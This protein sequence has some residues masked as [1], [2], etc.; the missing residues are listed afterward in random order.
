MSVADLDERA[1]RV[2][3]HEQRTNHADVAVKPGGLARFFT[4]WAT[5][6]QAAGHP[7][8]DRLMDMFAAYATLDPMQR[9]AR[10]RAALA[11]LA[12]S[13]G[14]AAAPAR[15]QA[16]S[17]PTK[18]PATSST[19]ARA[20]SPRGPTQPAPASDAAN[21]KHARSTDSQ[22]TAPARSPAAK[23]T[24]SSERPGPSPTG[25]QKVPANTPKP[26]VTHDSRA[27]GLQRPAHEPV[28]EYLLDA[29]VTSVAGVGPAI[30]AKFERLG[31]RTVR[32]LLYYLPRE[33][34][35]YSK[36]QKI[37]T[38]PLD[39]VVTTLG[40]IWE[41]QNVRTPNGRM[42]RTIARI[43][44]ETGEIRAVW[45][46]Q[47]Y[48]LKQ[49]PR[50]AQ[51][52]VTGVK[53]RFGNSIQFTVRSHELPEQGDL[54]NTG[55]LVPVYPLTEGLS[56][57]TLRRATKWAVDRCADLVSDYLPLAVRQSAHLMPLPRALAEFHYPESGEALHQARHRLGF[58]E[59]FIVQLGMLARRANWYVG[60]SAPRIVVDRTR[61][62][63]PPPNP[64]PILANGEGENDAGVALLNGDLVSL[65]ADLAGERKGATGSTSR[66][67]DIPL[68]IRQNGEPNGSVP[69]SGVGLP[70]P[71]GLWGETLVTAQCFEE[72][73]PFSF[74]EAQRRVICEILDDME[75]DRPMCRL[76]QGDVGS[77]KTAVAAAAM[78]AAALS[79][80]QAAIMAPTEILAE[81]HGRALA[82][83]LDPF[84]MQVALLLGS[85][86]AKQRAEALAAIE[87]GL[88]RVVVGT[89]ALI[90]ESVAFARLGLAVVDEQHRFGVEQRE[91]L[92]RKARDHSPHLLVMTATP[93]PRTLA[94]AVYGDL[95]LSIIDQ[96]PRGRKPVV[97]R[98]RA[99]A[100]RDEA[101]QQMGWEVAQGRQGYII[102]P[103]IEE[104]EALEAK[105]A[106]VEFERLR[107]EI[108][109]DLRLGLV[110]GGLKPAEKDTTMRKFRDGDLDILVAT[111]VVE[112][113]V[114][115]PNATMMIIEDADRFGLAQLHQFRGRVGRG[116]HQSY[117]Y[118]LSQDAGA[119]ARERLTAVEGTTDGF[120]LA[121]I[122]LQ[123]RGPGEFFGTR[124]S[125]LPE[126]RVAELTD[127]ALIAQ[128]RQEAEKLWQRD[129]FLKSHEHSALRERV[130]RF[131]Q[132]YMAQ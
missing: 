119:Q 60:P 79:G 121:E 27:G 81:Q 39:E 104:S 56:A 124:Q 19:P 15:Q 33:H 57:K 63:A 37:G 116:E 32:D 50:G 76:V 130:A 20:T 100:R 114:D 21:G 45:F 102:C 14:A 40:V 35:D 38:L 96:M 23:Q 54:V 3:A 117:C 86:R 82:K 17:A 101:F 18:S 13:D 43:S 44:D 26:A 28:G 93:I 87:S 98:W 74:T 103:L 51:I 55:R 61:I 24:H 115:V 92:R 12:P 46:N 29:P 47:P 59:M 89:H 5:D 36:L 65:S 75:R 85:Q 131:W 68:S 127:S 62:L 66:S 11:L 111:A 9:A 97:T 125:G 113:G 107:T 91:A 70:A 31:I 77:G 16:V 4:Y 122:D 94:L 69:G 73:L 99:G 2:L 7:L 71:N 1:R 83:M 58:D 95:D 30:A 132:N 105:A 52:V 80:Y 90:Q 22:P 118:L 123:L 128:T 49:L 10:V 48:L 106:T 108:F 110:H 64:L 34:H 41:A 72:S 129:P 53:Q 126:L 120:K 78:L 88:A 25:E 67:N 112:V 84:G 109:P 8:A 42:T 6:A